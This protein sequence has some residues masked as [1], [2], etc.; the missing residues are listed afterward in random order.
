M[1]WLGAELMK[2]SRA[3]LLS[4]ITLTC[5][6]ASAQES[7]AVKVEV[8]KTGSGFI[9]LRDG[10]PYDIR[11]AGLENGDIS[12]FAENGGNTIRNW[13]TA[14]AQA[15]LDQALVHGVAVV[16]CLPVVPER[17]G[18]DY[19]DSAAVAKQLEFMRHEVQ[20]YKDHPALLGWIIGNEL[21]FDYTNPAVYD[22]VNNISMMI[23]QVDP[24]HPTTTTVAGLGI[25]VVRDLK[26]RAWDLDILSFQVYGELANV[27]DFLEMADLNRPIFI[28]E[29]GAIGHWEMPKTKWQAA[30]EMN[31]SE[32]A[33]VYLQGYENYISPFKDEIIGSFA[34]LWGQK[35]ERTPTWFGMFTEDGK[36]TETV[37]AMHRIWTGEWPANRT[38]A[39]ISFTIDGK[40]ASDD[41]VLEAESVFSAE[42][43]ISDPEGG[44]VDYFWEI[45]PESNA[46]EVGGDR[47][48]IIE[49]IVMN[50]E[51]LS[52]S[53]MRITAPTET[54]A[55][56]LY[57]Y[58]YD[59]NNQVAHA[60]IPFLVAKDI[61]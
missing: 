42:A 10:K 26:N 16:L 23:H 14:N 27:P 55:Y 50:A 44:P 29:W 52:P 58:A 37:D 41:I 11:G 61:Q 43:L 30:I 48:T 22:A 28:T 53:S 20:K 57:V 39:V 3:F 51:Q 32:K 25:D 24:N 46:L 33:G 60:N 4:L 1:S 9:L 7:G 31:S 6:A 5:V 40:S 35:Q 17:W 21:N 19:S 12:S 38:P 36:K 56:R 49:S 59:D 45:K 47:E 13:S 18:F 15:V 34:F 2:C 54:G 8:A